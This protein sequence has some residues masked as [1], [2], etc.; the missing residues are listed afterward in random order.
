MTFSFVFH[1]SFRSTRTSVDEMS[2]KSTALLRTK[3]CSWVGDSCSYYPRLSNPRATRS[4]SFRS[5][6]ETRAPTKKKNRCTGSLPS[7]TLPWKNFAR[8]IFI[9]IFWIIAI[10]THGVAR[11]LANN[12][13]LLEQTSKDVENTHHF[14]RLPTFQTA[15]T[16]PC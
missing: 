14:F 9:F 2:G 5:F 6:F 16:V 7:K 11:Q 15:T 13:D 8:R 10:T 3:V 12:P 4:W 1:S